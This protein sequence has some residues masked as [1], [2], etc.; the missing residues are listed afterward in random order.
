MRD[1]RNRS[2]TVLEMAKM[3]VLAPAGALTWMVLVELGALQGT[4]MVLFAK[5]YWY[6]ATRGEH[7][8]PLGLWLLVNLPPAGV[9]LWALG[10]GTFQVFDSQMQMYATIVVVTWFA[11]STGYLILLG[12]LANMPLAR[13]RTA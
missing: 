8:E 9:L 13:N 3:I 1:D 5:G 6:V 11:T 4:A 10:G 2:A 7:V 12:I